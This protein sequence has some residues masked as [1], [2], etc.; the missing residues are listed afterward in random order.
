MCPSPECVCVCVCVLQ[1]YSDLNRTMLWGKERVRM[2]AGLHLIS[3]H[4]HT[5]HVTAANSFTT[6]QVTSDTQFLDALR[7]SQ[8]GRLLLV[9]GA[10]R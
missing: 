4:P 10:V 8:D 7:D 2:H 5:G 6:W 9:A 1:V 3:L